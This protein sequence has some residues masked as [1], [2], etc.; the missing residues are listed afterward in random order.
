M[1]ENSTSKNRPESYTLHEIISCL[2][3]TFSEQNNAIIYNFLSSDVPANCF[4][5]INEINQ[6]DV[7]KIIG[8][9]SLKLRVDRVN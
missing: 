9:C 8:Y 7:V 6:T 5:L 1:D 4:I 3:I 2:A